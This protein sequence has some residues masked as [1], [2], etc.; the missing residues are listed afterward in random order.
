MW[1]VGG[2]W[3]WAQARDTDAELAGARDD[4]RHLVEHHRAATQ[5]VK[6]ASA[7]QCI[8]V[9]GSER[10]TFFANAQRGA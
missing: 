1:F 4:R 5:Q 2:N 10:A 7:A 6:H 3:D 9:A 8:A